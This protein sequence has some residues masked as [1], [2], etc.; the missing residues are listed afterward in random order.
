VTLD[1]PTDRAA[2][3]LGRLFALLERIEAVALGEAPRESSDRLF[4]EASATPAQSFPALLRAAQHYVT[5]SLEGL[6]LERGVAEVLAR[7]PEGELPA[8]LDREGRRS[9]ALGYAHERTAFF[10]RPLYT[11]RPPAPAPGSL[12]PRER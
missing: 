5:R 1:Q 11:S 4:S 9:F 3:L 7:L 10:E 8:E 2:Y 6:W 12:D